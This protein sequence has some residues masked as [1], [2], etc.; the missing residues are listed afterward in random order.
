M[1]DTREF[2]ETSARLYA[3]YAGADPRARAQAA[4]A[5]KQMLRPLVAKRCAI[6]GL[7]SAEVEDVWQET[8][9]AVEEA[10]QGPD[11]PSV[12]DTEDFFWFCYWRARDAIRDIVRARLPGL[13]RAPAGQN[14][15]QYP[16]E[17]IKDDRAEQAFARIAAITEEE[18]RKWLA[19]Y[20][21]QIASIVLKGLSQV[22]A[23]ESRF[24]RREGLAPL[25]AY[26]FD[27]SAPSDGGQ[28]LDERQLASDLR[29]TVENLR[30]RRT[31]E[32]NK[33]RARLEPLLKALKGELH[34]HAELLHDD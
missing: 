28:P 9:L 21:P 3:A 20:L 1:D 29:I 19:Q 11:S 5:L 31:R 10:L 2:R 14:E 12:G 25:L 33:L 7:S 34:E 27:A 13:P 32:L 6:A 17:R 23:D 24:E 8:F 22:A 4:E 30:V 15:P 26:Y 18:R 16:L